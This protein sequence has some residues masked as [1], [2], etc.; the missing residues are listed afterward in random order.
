MVKAK[1]MV[2]GDAALVHGFRL[3]G[4]EDCILTTNEKFQKDLEDYLAKPEFGV[5]VVNEIM[6]GNID[7]RL[8]KKLDMLA[9]PVIVPMPD[10]SGKS[11][12]GDEIRGLIKRALGFDL[13]AKK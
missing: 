13:G 5:I 1:I 9:Y 7:W 8:K 10:I 3:T 4:L 2:L 6:L 11:S 12:E